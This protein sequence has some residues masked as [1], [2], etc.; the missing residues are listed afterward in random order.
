[1][2]EATQRTYWPTPQDYTEAVRNLREN[3]YDVTLQSAA[4]ESDEKGMPLSLSGGA[5]VVYHLTCADRQWALRCFLHN[6][7]DSAWR[8][9]QIAHF[10]SNDKLSYTVN[11]DY[12]TQGI[13]VQD[14]WFPILKMEW[15]RGKSLDRYLREHLQEKSILEALA[16]SFAGMCADLLDAG[17]AHGDLQNSNI[18]V[19]DDGKLH[20]VDYDAMYV[21]IM[22]GGMSAELG[23][24]N[25]QHPYRNGQHFGDY[26][27]NFAAW[28]IY[29]SLYALAVEPSLFDQL[30]VGE[31]CLL[32]RHGDF[33]N[34]LD[35][36]AF[37]VLERH[38]RGEIRLMAQFIRSQ[39]N[40]PPEQMPP[41]GSLAT[42]SVEP[43]PPLHANV[44]LDRKLWQQTNAGAPRASAAA[45]GEA[46]RASNSSMHPATISGAASHDW[47]VTG[48]YAP[49]VGQAQMWQP[50][51]QEL[52]QPVP[53]RVA[54]DVAWGGSDFDPIWIAVFIVG[55]AIACAVAH[56]RGTPVDTCIWVFAT[57]LIASAFFAKR[58][59]GQQRRRMLVRSG[60]TAR[61]TIKQLVPR[62][63]NQRYHL[64]CYE[65]DTGKRVLT[66]TMTLN[67]EQLA[68]VCK[69][70]QVT[71]LH[72]PRYGSTIYKLCSYRAV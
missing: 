33:L 21:P 67:D 60:Q 72:H 65:F 18:L 55:L 4:V 66:H 63:S 59:S 3:L 30:G 17:I 40:R 62:A 38:A 53:R 35:S 8:Y 39:L 46:L 56:A 44:P 41:L 10:V 19:D 34:P 68:S 1:M 6:T 5:A 61:G 32:F 28:V 31:D 14:H 43:L 64:V 69:H 11:L 57:G 26:L 29:L 42:I 12:Q 24:P 2:Q 16:G 58:M 71:V 36:C 37:A 15:A 52:Q 70:E 20:L 13:K 48:E 22:H 49:Q 9:Q 27:D 50:P 54:F 23:H 45:S 25:F 47:Q 51:E 7:A